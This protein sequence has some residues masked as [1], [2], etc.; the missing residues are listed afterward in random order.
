M[1]RVYQSLAKVKGISQE[2]VTDV[3]ATLDDRLYGPEGTWK[4]KHG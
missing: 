1:K 2:P 4:G 3:S